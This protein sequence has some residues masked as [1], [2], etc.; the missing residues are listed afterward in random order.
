M[1]SHLL[2]HPQS[3]IKKKKLPKRSVRGKPPTPVDIHEEVASADAEDEWE[4]DENEEK[5]RGL[6]VI[7]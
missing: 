5:D 6:H 1:S 3:I 2:R 7:G 4:E